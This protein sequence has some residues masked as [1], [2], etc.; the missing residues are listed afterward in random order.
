[1][2]PTLTSRTVNRTTHLTSFDF[3]YCT[4]QRLFRLLLPNTKFIKQL[5]FFHSRL[6]SDSLHCHPL[7]GLTAESFLW[8]ILLSQCLLSNPPSSSTKF[9]SQIFLKIP[10]SPQPPWSKIGH[11]LPGLLNCLPNV[12]ATFFQPLSPYKSLYRHNDPFK[13]F[14]PAAPTLKVLQWLSNYNCK[15]NFKKFKFFSDSQPPLV[16]KQTA[17]KAMHDLTRPASQP[18]PC[19]LSPY[20]LLPV[21]H[22]YR[23]LSLKRALQISF[24]M[25]GIPFLPLLS[26]VNTYYPHRFTR[27]A[28]DL[29]NKVTHAHSTVF[30]FIPVIMWWDVW[31]FNNYLINGHLPL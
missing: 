19:L 6:I 29:V 16:Q 21:Y 4:V 1:M 14:Y 8:H 15:N 24:L 20:W 3:S 25:L 11:R 13:I 7:P 5:A 30:L 22:H 28:S 2:S 9:T 26:L 31:L 10:Y 23:V 27:E 17:Y 18:H 12:L